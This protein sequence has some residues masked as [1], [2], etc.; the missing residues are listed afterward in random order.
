M[1]GWAGR[2]KSGWT[3]T[4]V[5]CSNVSSLPEV[6]GNVAKYFDPKDPESIARA[7]ESSIDDKGKYDNEIDSW[8]SLQQYVGGV[9]RPYG[10]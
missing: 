8:V 7:L 9:I 6:G 4:P 10:F 2:R 1:P 5:A 3:S